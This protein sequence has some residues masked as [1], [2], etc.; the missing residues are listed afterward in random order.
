VAD[1]P[2]LQVSQIFSL[3]K[4]RRRRVFLGD[5][6][7]KHEIAR[8]SMGK[9]YLA[10]QAAFD[11]HVAVKFLAR[12]LCDD[13][14][15]VERFTH[16]A[17]AT[18]AVQHPHVV[19]I[20]GRGDVKGRPYIAMECLDGG[21]LADRVNRGGPMRP[22]EAIGFMR[23]AAEGLQA[24]WEQGLIH[25]DITPRNLMISAEG[26]LKVTD[27]GLAK[28]VDGAR[29]KGGGTAADVIVGTPHYMSPEQARGDHL[30][31][32]SDIY[33]LG[34]TF[35]HLMAGDV[36]FDDETA[37]GILVKHL[38][39]PLPPLQ[40]KC[41]GIPTALCATIERM[42]HKDPNER[43]QTWGELIEHLSHLSTGYD[44][45][46]VITQ[47]RL[48]V[49]PTEEGPDGVPAG[50]RRWVYVLVLFALVA[51]LVALVVRLHP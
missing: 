51:L 18:A 46:K 40:D 28:R 30:D 11:R 4:P 6:E 2:L 17:K 5:F 31:C 47:M 29:R 25:R 12:E 27:F 15:T 43:F 3:P 22:D 39:E 24:A 41:K 13:P 37:M 45:R 34:A 23:Q 44:S 50:R 8:G 16:E 19:A 32:R 14:E 10:Y 7:L 21:S 1:D 42:M 35:Y 38:E 20:L 36:P 49:R 9:V 26:D 48:Q 33:S